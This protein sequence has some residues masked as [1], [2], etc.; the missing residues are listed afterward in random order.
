MEDT[1][2]SN[3]N[4]LTDNVKIDLNMLGALVLNNIDGEVDGI[5]IVAVDQSGPRQ[6]VV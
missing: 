1:N 3:G 4:T 2:I 6:G 5:N